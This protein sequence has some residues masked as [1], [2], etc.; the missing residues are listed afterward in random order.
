MK[1]A[2]F[3]IKLI[4]FPTNIQ[5]RMEM[6]PLRAM[7]LEAGPI[8]GPVDQLVIDLPALCPESKAL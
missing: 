1:F 6:I 5:Y 7:S 2:L 3:V 8:I 4:F